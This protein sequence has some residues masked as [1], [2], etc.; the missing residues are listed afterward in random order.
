MQRVFVDQLVPIH[1][2]LQTHKGFSRV[3]HCPVLVDL[4]KFFF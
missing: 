3:S 2:Y 4:I 1:I